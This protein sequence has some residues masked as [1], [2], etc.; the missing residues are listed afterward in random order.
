MRPGTNLQQLENAANV[1]Q[2]RLRDLDSEYRPL[3]KGRPELQP[4]WDAK[5]APLLA[6]IAERDA[7]L[8]AHP[9]PVL[10]S[11]GPGWPKKS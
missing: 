6:T 3:V 4:E 10:D 1:A 7:F 9:Q 2:D 8:K 5:R 11:D